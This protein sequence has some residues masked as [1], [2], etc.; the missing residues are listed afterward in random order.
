MNKKKYR[1][2]EKENVVYIYRDKRVAL[3]GSGN[4]K[5]KINMLKYCIIDVIHRFRRRDT[6]SFEYSHNWLASWLGVSQNVIS[7]HIN[8]LIKE[9]LLKSTEFGLVLT[10]EA[11]LIFHEE[12]E[13]E[14]QSFYIRLSFTYKEKI[15]QQYG[16]ITIEQYAILM[17]I[18]TLQKKRHRSFEFSFLSRFLLLNRNT[19]SNSVKIL[20]EKGLLCGKLEVSSFIEDMFGE[21]RYKSLRELYFENDHLL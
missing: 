8:Y 16:A 5:R 18:Y 20:M 17:A 1:I 7:L 3:I 12:R 10:D 11:N 21:I 2:K 14:E 9:N 4:Q 15:A 6:L 13:F 19:I